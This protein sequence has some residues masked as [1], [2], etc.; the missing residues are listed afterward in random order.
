MFDDFESEEQQERDRQLAAERLLI[1]T[2]MVSK[3][4]EAF[5]PAEDEYD[6]EQV[7]TTDEL[8]LSLSKSVALIRIDSEQFIS[9]MEASGFNLV[10]ISSP[11]G[12]KWVW[13][14]KSRVAD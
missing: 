3:L 14:L 11:L 12:P 6:A 4:A 1:T 7:S 8:L 2:M 13:L 9:Q 5:S 10:C